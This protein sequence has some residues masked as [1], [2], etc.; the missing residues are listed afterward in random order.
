[1]L[2]KLASIAFSGHSLFFL[3]FYAIES[4]L[5]DF[6][7]WYTSPQSSPKNFSTLVLRKLEFLEYELELKR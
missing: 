5:V 7:W 4:T 1:M 2:K 6:F 3:L